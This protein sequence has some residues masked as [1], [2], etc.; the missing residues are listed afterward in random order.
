MASRVW[1]GQLRHLYNIHG[2]TDTLFAVCGHL[3][4]DWVPFLTDVCRVSMGNALAAGGAGIGAIAT[5][6]ILA[7]LTGGTSLA[8]GLAA[9]P[10]SGA[11]VVYHNANCNTG[12][13]GD[14]V[15]G[16]VMAMQSSIS[17]TKK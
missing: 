3:A 16:A 17:V 13:R 2:Y 14:L 1:G 12:N 11:T 5:G 8:V 7:P 9:L 10:V 4:D 15:A 6:V